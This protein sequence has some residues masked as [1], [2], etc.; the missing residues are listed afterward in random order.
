[1]TY[2]GRKQELIL[3]FASVQILPIRERAIGERSVDGDL[4][5]FVPEALEEPMRHAER[6]VLGII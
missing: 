4:I 1:M 2:V 6:P 5:G 3:R